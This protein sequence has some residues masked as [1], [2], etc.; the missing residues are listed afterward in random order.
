MKVVVIYEDNH[1]I[2]GVANN[3]YNAVRFLLE[4][5]W[6]T[7]E[8]NMYDGKTSHWKSIEEYLGKNWEEYLLN[9]CDLNT[10]ND[11]FEN[12]LEL[13]LTEVYGTD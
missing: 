9:E 3:Y 11:I 10:F 8:T 12:W 7:Y 5:Q 2:I 4:E 1:G 13:S 6:I